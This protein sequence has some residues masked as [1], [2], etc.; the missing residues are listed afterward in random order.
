MVSL[1]VTFLAVAGNVTPYKGSRIFWDTTSRS[2][3]FGTGWYARMIQLQDGRL[4]AACEHGGIDISFSNNG[5]KSWTSPTK[6]V[7]NTNNVPNC[8]PDLIQ[9]KDGTIIVAYNPRPNTPYT[10][11]R[12]FGMRCKRS[13]D[14]GTT[15][16][17]E[18]FVYDASYIWDDGCWEPSLIELPSGELQLYYSDEGPYTNSNEQNMSVCRSFDGGLTWSKP[19]IVSYRAGY[20]D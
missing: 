7:S 2:V 11:D 14:N 13:T 15:W 19:D 1:S 16:S 5:G 4:M 20:S 12:H 18:I 3:V 10:E 6:I 17:N 8:V 9:L